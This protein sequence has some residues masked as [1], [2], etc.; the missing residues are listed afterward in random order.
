MQYFFGTP[1]W[2]YYA[3]KR[4]DLSC[5]SL[6]VVGSQNTKFHIINKSFYTRQSN[7]WK[8]MEKLF[9]F[10]WDKSALISTIRQYVPSCEKCLPPFFYPNSHDVMTRIP[11]FPFSMHIL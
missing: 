4:E 7:E 11:A 5:L 10:N 6:D 3:Y 8:E 2:Y 9:P 1:F